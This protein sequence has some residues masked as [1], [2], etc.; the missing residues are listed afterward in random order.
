MTKTQVVSSRKGMVAFVHVSP[1]IKSAIKADFVDRRGVGVSMKGV[2]R[3]TI[4]KS[5]INALKRL[6]KEHPDAELFFIY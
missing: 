5:G 4:E 1:D 6:L 3:Q 2:R